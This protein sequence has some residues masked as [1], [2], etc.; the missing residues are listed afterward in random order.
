M[1]ESETKR[2]RRGRRWLFAL[3]ALA[4]CCGLGALALRHYLQPD[5]LTALLI[6]QTRSALGADLAV[7]GAAGFGFVP[8]LH[9]VL[10][11]PALKA[12]G[13]GTAFLAADSLDAV[14]PWR[15]LW[16]GRYEIERIELVKPTLDLDALSAWLAARPQPRAALPDVRFSLHVSDGSVMRGEKPIAQGIRMDFASSG[17]VAGWLAKFDPKSAAVPLLP[18]LGGSADVS[19]VQIGDTRLDGMHVEVRDDGVTAKPSK[20]P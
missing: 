12:P 13:T 20:Q 3:L 18:P 6:E 17:D 7:T 10:P 1:P 16:S 11:R 4:L 9:L 5:Q 14:V 8:N 19:S 2:P 15:S